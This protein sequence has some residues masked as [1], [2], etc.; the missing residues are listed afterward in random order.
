M[1]HKP[2]AAVVSDQPSGN[3]AMLELCGAAALEGVDVTIG[4]EANGVPEP[5]RGLQKKANSTISHNMH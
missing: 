5:E 4:S 2:I 3:A 1:S